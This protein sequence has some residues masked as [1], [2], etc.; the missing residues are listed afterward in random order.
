MIPGRVSPP[1]VTSTGPDGMPAATSAIT[2]TN[3]SAQN[4]IDGASRRSAYYLSGGDHD[5]AELGGRVQFTELDAVAAQHRDAVLALHPG[6]GH[7]RHQSD[8]PVA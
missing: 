2:G 1:M 6:R 3:S 4:T 5:S 7:R 8:C